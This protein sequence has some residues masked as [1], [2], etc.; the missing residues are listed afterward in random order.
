MNELL[1]LLEQR[2]QSLLDEVDALRRDNA[3]LRRDLTEKQGLLTEE[4]EMVK[5]ALAREKTAR[6]AAAERINALLQRLAGRVPE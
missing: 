2:I 3:G 6:E 5:E 1:D 4:N